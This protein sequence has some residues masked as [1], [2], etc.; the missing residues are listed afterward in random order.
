M[1]QT[2]RQKSNLFLICFLL[3]FLPSSVFATV[4]LPNGQGGGGGPSTDTLQDVTNRGATTTV[5]SNFSG[6]IITPQVTNVITG[7]NLIDYQMNTNSA[8]RYSLT[9]VNSGTSARAGLGLFNGALAGNSAFL[10]LNGVGYTG[11]AGWA[12]RFTFQTGSLVSNGMIFYAVNGGIQFSTSGTNNPD[13]FVAP[14][15]GYVGKGTT[16]PQGH[17][18]VQGDVYPISRI[19]RTTT[20]IHNDVRSALD[21]KF[22]T[23]GNMLDNFGPAITFVINDN[24][25]VDNIIG[26]IAYLRDGADNSGKFVIYTYNGGVRSTRFQIDKAGVMS[27]GTGATMS[28]ATNIL[29]NEGTNVKIMRSRS[30]DNTTDS[31]AS[32]SSYVNDVGV[33]ILAHAGARTITRYGI[34]LG[35]WG[36][37]LTT[38]GNT[39][40]PKG[41]IIGTETNAPIVFATNN[42]ERGR[43]YPNGT[44]NFRQD[45]IVNGTVYA[46]SFASLSPYAFT[47]DTKFCRVAGNGAIV[48]ETIELIKGEYKSVIIEDTQGVCQKTKTSE[49]IVG[50]N[51][52]VINNDVQEQYTVKEETKDLWTGQVTSTYRTERGNSLEH[53]QQDHTYYSN[54]VFQH[55]GKAY[56]VTANKLEIKPKEVSELPEIFEK[57]TPVIYDRDLKSDSDLKKEII[58]EVNDYDSKRYYDVN[59]EFKFREDTYRA[60]VQNA[61]VPARTPTEYPQQIQEIL[62]NGVVR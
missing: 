18:H 45:L 62:L 53:F 31:V 55:N 32:Q 2:K 44:V 59:E 42:L 17:F 12:N 33:S 57:V 4:V 6:G 41:M 48:Y 49:D 51:L 52:V 10:N 36:E 21:L 38:T 27:T 29:Y 22:K 47:G 8:E 43:I 35:G 39:G 11:V 24:L 56:K 28:F 23:T 5:Q 20:G 1:N 7:S 40:S 9:N 37:L 54:N 19:E 15:T 14:I 16:N 26:Q 50:K 58:K 46:T 25:N 34:Q 60:L 3:I 61:R 13:L 30:I